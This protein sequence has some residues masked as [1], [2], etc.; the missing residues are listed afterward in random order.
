M[1]AE[2]QLNIRVDGELKRTF[3]E[4]AKA[5]GTNA[6][7]LLVGFMKEYLGIQSD[8]PATSIGAIEA[9]LRERL[10]ERLTEIESRLEARLEE[11]LVK[12]QQHL[13]EVAA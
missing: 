10:E 5:D 6:T 7:E 11:R 13:G 3:I 8:D 4:R 2:N 1:S 9:N 12:I